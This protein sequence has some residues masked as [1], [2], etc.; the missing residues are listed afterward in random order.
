MCGD[1]TV[2]S[3]SLSLSGISNSVYSLDSGGADDTMAGWLGRGGS[4]RKGK[5]VSSKVT[6]VEMT[7]L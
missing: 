1:V 7:N 6:S 4:M 5:V 2:M 3:S